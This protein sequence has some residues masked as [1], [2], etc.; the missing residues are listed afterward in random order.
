MVTLDDVDRRIL[1]LLQANARRTN[2]E[3][4][5]DVGLTAPSVFERIRKLEQRGVIRGYTV[6][7]DPQ[8]LGKPLTAFIRLTAAYD[9]RHAAGVQALAADPDVL[10]CYSVAGEDCFIIK[11]RVSDPSALQALIHRIRGQLT[12]LRSVTM[13]A[14]SAV[15]EGGPLRAAA[16]QAERR[17]ARNGHSAAPVRRRGG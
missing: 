14:L 11:T 6:Q 8:A 2:A 10:E 12:V 3:I 7:V 17:P 16:P 9:D 4:A 5:E 15:K 1:D 13:I